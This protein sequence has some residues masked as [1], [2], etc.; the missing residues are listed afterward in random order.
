VPNQGQGRAG[1][2]TSLAL[3]SSANHRGTSGFQNL[4]SPRPFQH[5][6]GS[7]AVRS[8]P[9]ASMSCCDASAIFTAPPRFLHHGFVDAPKRVI[10]RRFGCS[11]LFQEI[12]SIRDQIRQ[13]VVRYNLV[14]HQFWLRHVVVRAPSLGASE[15]KS[16]ASA[17]W[18]RCFRVAQVLHSCLAGAACRWDWRSIPPRKPIDWPSAPLLPT[19]AGRAEPRIG[20]AAL[21]FRRAVPCA[22]NHWRYSFNGCSVPSLPLSFS[23]A[24]TEVCL[25]VAHEFV[26]RLR[27]VANARLGGATISGA[28][29][30]SINS[31]SFLSRWCPLPAAL[32][33]HSPSLRSLSH[34]VSGANLHCRRLARHD[35]LADLFL[36]NILFFRAPNTVRSS[37]SAAPL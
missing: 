27:F 11:R 22:R 26:R 36:L 1:N 18:L 7:L 34:P 16:Y 33:A 15:T 10:R 13:R 8:P 28:V 6:P 9:S 37:G 31:A 29:A 35:E 32:R 23:I 20:P 14:L 3:I 12:S 24:P 17:L 21:P 30:S 25:G 5:S 19:A 4:A 2:Q